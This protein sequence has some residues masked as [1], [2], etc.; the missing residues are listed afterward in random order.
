MHNKISLIGHVGQQPEIR[1]V[2]ESKVASFSLGVTERGYTTKNGTKV[3]DKTTW[4]RVG[5][6]KGLAE[7]C[8]RYVNKGD[9][10][11]VEGKMTSRE[12]EKDGIRN[13]TWEVTATEIELLTSKKEGGN[14]SANQNTDAKR[15]NYQNG[16]DDGLPF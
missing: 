12:Y 14:Q 16:R 11:F 9:K 4:F 13:V 15:S 1:T 5:A 2:G 7:I 8:E 10:L 3:E 6:W